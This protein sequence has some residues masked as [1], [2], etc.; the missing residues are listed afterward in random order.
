MLSGIS[1]VLTAT[2]FTLAMIALGYWI[3][4]CDFKKLQTPGTKDLEVRIKALEEAVM[5]LINEKISQV[6]TET[7]KLITRLRTEGGK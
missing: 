2:V 5:T 1:L 4:V 6:K 3:G 7:D